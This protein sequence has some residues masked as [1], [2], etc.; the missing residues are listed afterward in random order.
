MT[1]TMRE[2]AKAAII[3]ELDR[4]YHAT[5]DGPFL[6]GEGEE[7]DRIGVDGRVNIAELLD[8]ILDTLREPDE[9][10]ARAGALGIHAHMNGDPM[11]LGATID[12]DK[13]PHG[14]D[15]ELGDDAKA[16]FTAM[17]D[18]IKGAR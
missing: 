10:M 11:T 4:Q 9:G 1:T 7:P 2:K 17:I 18:S 13:L 15:E 8:A 6:Y 16:A 3:A 5:P 12:F 14:W